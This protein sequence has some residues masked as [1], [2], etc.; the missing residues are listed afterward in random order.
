MASINIKT[1]KKVVPVIYCYTTPEIKRHDGWVKIGYSERE[2]ESRIGQQAN[3]VDVI[4]KTEWAKN[5]VFDD[6]SGEVFRDS[7]FHRYLTKN[8]IER[9]KGREWFHIDPI[10]AKRMLDDFR[11]NHGILQKTNAILSYRLRREQ[12]EAVDRAVD[13]FQ[14]HEDGQFL[15]NAKPRFGKTLSVYDL[16]KRMNAAKVLIVTNRP[17][18]ANSWYEDYTKFIGRE[19]GYFFVS[20][21]DGVKDRP[22]VISMESYKTDEKS[23]KERNLPLMKMICFMSL[24]DM[25]GSVYFG[26]KFEKLRD[27]AHTNWDLL[28]IDEAHEGVDTYKTDIAFDKVKRKHTLHLS[29]TPFKALANE[30]FPADAIYNWTYADEQKAK[31]G[32]KSPEGDENPYAN[33]PQ[34]NMYTYQMSEIIAD[35]L[36]RGAEINGETEEYAFD[37]NEFFATKENGFFNHNDSVDRFLDALTKQ[38]KFPFSTPELRDELKHTLWLLNR[39]DSAKA[40]AKKLKKHPVFKDYE[41]VLAAGDGRLDDDTETAKSFDRVKA[42]I[43]NN[44]KTITL[45]VGQLTTGVT[46]PE[47]TAVLM[48]SSIQSPGLYMQAAFR[49]QNPCLFTNGT[50]CFR[51]QNAY[52]FDF[53]PA[54]TLIIFEKFANDLSSNTFGGRGDS[55]QREDNIR[56]L[57]NFF[58]VIG[59][60]ENGEMILLDAAQVLSIPRKIK[61]REVVRRGFMSDFLFQNISNVFRAPLEVIE[62]IK[63]MTPAK[64]PGPLAGITPETGDKLNLNDDGEVEL[65]DELVIGTASDLFGEKIFNDSTLQDTLSD[66]VGKASTENPASKESEKEDLERLNA[67]KKAFREQVT[68]PITNKVAEEYGEYM[69]SRSEKKLQDKINNHADNVFDRSFG[70]Y[71]TEKRSLETDRKTKLESAASEAEAAEINREFDDKQKKAAEDFKEKMAETIDTMVKEAGNTA[72]RDVETEKREKEKR[73]MVDSVKDHLRGFSR[74]I[75]SF[76]MAYGDDGTTLET[77]D[78][79]IPDEVFL[80]VTSITLANFR[81]LRDGGDYENP[82]TGEKEHFDGHLFDPIVFNDSVK[83]FLGLKIKLADYFDEAMTEDIFDYIPPQKTN[84]IFTPKPTVKEMVDM[85]EKENPG[86]FDDPDHTF[87]D[88]YMKSGMYLTEIVK[89]L[90]QSERMKEIFPDEKVRLNHIFAKQVYGLAPTEIIYR[91]CLSYIM[92]FSS[93]IEIEKH[94]IRLCDALEYAKAGTLNQKLEEM[95]PELKG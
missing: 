56:E 35:E 86:C 18:I 25:K 42:A 50:Q 55:E 37:L 95:F 48:L 12:Q 63:Q 31:A 91:I 67:L 15:F 88:L 26:G 64:D 80:D 89:R 54:R 2:A 68:A 16:C 78:I 51:K 6:G 84:Q 8:G 87:A 47:W 39:V 71:Q 28:V 38:E 77:F 20:S 21:V 4:Y 74:T 10:T 49:A 1:S 65:P 13:Y 58:P 61:S 43:G 57:M 32:W 83:E 90:Y 27:V 52:V 85:L 59:E 76:L 81:L 29:G 93:E 82:D 79:I 53:D 75:P 92:G 94:N 69:T 19:G 11:E 7:D 40:L 17:A 5:A 3:T 9:K 66:I 60:D 34:L 33:L 36:S 72:V 14:L 62:M 45:S 73:S 44:D 46:I 41:I 22:L 70:N 24:Q 23:R 30:K